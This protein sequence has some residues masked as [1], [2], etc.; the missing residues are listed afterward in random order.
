MAIRNQI[1]SQSSS[2]DARGVGREAENQIPPS[3]RDEE[4]RGVRRPRWRVSVNLITQKGIS[5]QVTTLLLPLPRFSDNVFVFHLVDKCFWQLSESRIR[6]CTAIKFVP[7]QSNNL[8]IGNKSGFIYE[9]EISEWTPNP[10]GMGGRQVL[11]YFIYI[12]R[13]LS[14]APRNRMWVQK[15][16]LFIG[17]L[18]AATELFMAILL[19]FKELSK[20]LNDEII[21]HRR[22]YK[23]FVLS[24]LACP[25]KSARFDEDVPTT[26]NFSSFLRLD[27]SAPAARQK[28]PR[29]LLSPCRRFHCFDIF[30][31]FQKKW[32]LFHF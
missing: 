29:I 8:L 23:N 28:L 22:R 26:R 14:W 25:H 7:Q 5:R 13:H 20:E 16:A 32:N 18:S 17:N 3:R 30:I 12:L 19:I 15:K 31:E 27:D 24:L 10:K 9:I 2:H 4:Q 21:C 11:R 6:S 1:I